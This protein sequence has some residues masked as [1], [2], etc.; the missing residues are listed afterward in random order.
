LRNVL[1][2]IHYPVFGGPHSQAVRLAPILEA[3]GWHLTVLLPD[4]HGNA[5][6]LLRDAGVDVMTMPLRRLRGTM[7]LRDHIEWA[8]SFWPE[9]KAIQ[10]VIAERGI[11]LVQVSGLVN[12]QGAVAAR[13]E[14]KAIVWQ[15]ID[16]RAPMSLR[17]IFM[18]IVTGWSDIVMTTGAAVAAVHPGC[19]QL[20]ERLRTFYMPVDPETFTPALVDASV[21]RARLG[22]TETDL[23]VGTV[24]NLNPQKGHENF[25]RAL[26]LVR[27]ELDG[28]K[29]V[30]V[31]S[32]HDTHRT[33]ERNLYR[34]ATSLGLDIGRDV[35]FTGGLRDV[36]AP[37]AAMDVFV[38][39]SVPHSEGAPAAV[40][41]AMMMAKPVIAT[42]T[43]SLHELIRQE[44]T[45]LVVPPLDVQAMA[46]AIV[47]LLLDEE[48]RTSM[49]AASREEAKD[50]F[51]TDE[52]AA[53]HIS[54]YED[55]LEQAIRRAAEH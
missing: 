10:C 9:A 46:D 31:G 54:A 53:I 43:G 22:F 41:E 28:V 55:A 35:V 15:I 18:P 17:R 3:Q 27:M 30:I 13:R 29:G 23:V 6:P 11:D 38:L 34:L 47:R 36:R 48:L 37:L 26:S 5:A 21:A 7:R 1:T 42:D 12:V 44:A 2:I 24:G 39:A 49:G 52:C 20:G 14:R 40:E 33:Y 50:R 32:S 51:S 8:S 19:R 25:L 45:G 4:E 16:T